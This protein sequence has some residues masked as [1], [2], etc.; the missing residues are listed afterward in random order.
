MA[1]VDKKIYEVSSTGL[2]TVSKVYNVQLAGLGGNAKGVVFAV[3]KNGNTGKVLRRTGPGSWVETTLYGGAAGAVSLRDVWVADTG[4]AVAVG[5][6]GRS[7]IYR[8]K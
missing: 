1:A 2:K 4:E 8:K 7:F 3:G 5:E 6:K